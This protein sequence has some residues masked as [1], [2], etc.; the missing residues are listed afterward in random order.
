MEFRLE[1]SPT[2]P[3]QRKQQESSI[4]YNNIPN[5]SIK[6]DNKLIIMK[7]YFSFD[8]RISRLEYLLSYAVVS[9]FSGGIFNFCEQSI[10]HGYPEYFW[11][12]WSLIMIPTM[13]VIFAQGAKR[14]H[15]MGRSGWY[16]L[17][18]FYV[19]WMVFA[20]GEKLAN[21][22]GRPLL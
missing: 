1:A 22:Y 9:I 10:L 13:W 7:H 4:S 14:C 16:Q 3:F 5:Y 18:P 12:V 17:I 11:P 2:T 6:W 19:I 21:K 20:P 8:G 15:D